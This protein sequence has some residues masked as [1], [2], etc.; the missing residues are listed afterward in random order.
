V[1]V[2]LW[3]NNHFASTTVLTMMTIVM[4]GA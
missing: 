3:Y 1:L 4:M 2:L